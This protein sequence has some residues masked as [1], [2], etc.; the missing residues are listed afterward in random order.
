MN[1][2]EALN[3][4]VIEVVAFTSASRDP[5][6]NQQR[7]QRPRYKKAGNLISHSSLS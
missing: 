7:F 5:I 2:Y 4:S 6:Y 1:L 3:S